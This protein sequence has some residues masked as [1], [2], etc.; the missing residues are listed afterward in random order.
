M[1][2]MVGDAAVLDGEDSQ[3][4]KMFFLFH[5]VTTTQVL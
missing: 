1:W 2:L 5:S 4:A 3:S